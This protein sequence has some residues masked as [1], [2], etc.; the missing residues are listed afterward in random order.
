MERR[1]AR[2][3]K[4]REVLELLDEIVDRGSAVMSNRVHSLLV[5]LFKY[6][7]HRQLIERAGSPTTLE[8]AS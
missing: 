6:G 1:D 5:Q 2:T 7:I 3:V 8:R 4:P